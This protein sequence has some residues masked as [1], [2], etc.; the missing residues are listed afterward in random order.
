MAKT[1]VALDKLKPS[2]KEVHGLLVWESGKV[3]ETALRESFLITAMIV[4]V[5]QT[6]CG[7]RPLE[8]HF[9]K[10]KSCEENYSSP[11]LIRNDFA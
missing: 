2:L 5:E 9:S 3:E 11:S 6:F 10:Q 7:N 8:A 4:E 1:H